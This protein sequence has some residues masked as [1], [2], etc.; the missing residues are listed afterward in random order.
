M[1]NARFTGFALGLALAVTAA[2][3]VVVAQGP[4]ARAR[5]VVTVLEAPG[6]QLGVMVRDLE[7]NALT[8][9]KGA[10]GVQ[11]DDVTDGS[12][13]HKAGLK[14]GDILVEYDGEHV[15]SA[16]QLMRLVEETPEG[17]SVKIAVLRNGQR[18]VVEAAPDRVESTWDARVD[19][20]RIRRELERGLRDLRGRREFRAEELPGFDFRFD[21]V[22]PMMSPRGRLGVTVMAL[23]PQLSDYFGAK[24]GGALVSSVLEDSPA[25]KAG[26]KAGD[27]ITSV[28]GSP[29][30]DARDVARAINESTTPEVTVG[31]VRDR[32]ETTVKTAIERP[33]RPERRGVARQPV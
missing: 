27:V 15:R 14:A 9:T 26:I 33:Q 30:N 29:V 11:I 7:G 23:S 19:G 28:N 16:R 21:E 18:Q 10:G 17:R 1:K 20:G 32:K 8:A 4:D 6:N 13:A 12:A 3:G 22:M 5:R 24:N 2:V 31:I 25:E